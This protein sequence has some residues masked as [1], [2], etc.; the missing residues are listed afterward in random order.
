MSGTTASTDVTRG[1][2][3]RPSRRSPSCPAI[4]LGVAVELVHVL[5]KNEG[6]Y[7]TPID[8]VLH[9]WGYPSRSRAALRRTSSLAQFGLTSE[10]GRGATRKV[11]LTRLGLQ[12]LRPQSASRQRALKQAALNP[13]A[14]EALYAR[15]PRGLPSDQSVVWHLRHER[16]F[17]PKAAWSFLFEYRATMRLAGLEAAAGLVA[18]RLSALLR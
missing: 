16:G 9:H 4:D 1:D 2:S 13:P 15:F 11:E 7:L 5:Y 10:Y 8:S 14:H 18:E 12:T 6:T 3:L 17:T